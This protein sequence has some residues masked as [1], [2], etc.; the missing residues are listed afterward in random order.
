MTAA[1]EAQDVVKRYHNATRNAVDGIS[2][3]IDPGQV[4]GVLGPNGAGKSTL[5]KLICGAMPPTDGA[6]TIFGGNPADSR[7]RRQLGAVHQVT[8]F[9]MMLKVSDNL[10]IAAAFRGLRWRTVRA[11]AEQLLEA[12]DLVGTVDQLV[13]TLSGGQLRRLQV[14]RALL[15]VPRLL[16]LDEPTAGMDVAGRRL[17]WRLL[18]EITAEHGTTVLWTSHNIDELE[19]NCESV[20]VIH[21]G[22][23]LQHAS[24]RSLVEQFGRRYLAVRPGNAEHASRIMALADRAGLHGEQETGAVRLSGPDVEDRL[25]ALLATLHEHGIAVASVEVRQMSLEDVFMA[26]TNADEDH[27]TVGS[28]A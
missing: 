16:L 15:R 21:R 2:F 5:I 10:R 22:R 8:S 9:D 24:P 20:L 13:F 6:V 1:V 12:F 7:V 4:V 23:L 18:D 11:H 19:R 14:V 27:R 26:L 17:V 25:P 3:T 28:A